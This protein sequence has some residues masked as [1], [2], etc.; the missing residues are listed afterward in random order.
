MNS[1]NLALAINVK[2]QTETDTATTTTTTTT[3]AATTTIATATTIV[4]NNLEA[5]SQYLQ[6]DFDIDSATKRRLPL[7]PKIKN[8]KRGKLKKILN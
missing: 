4:L 2:P 5:F 7:D 3:S 8:K 6:M 1:A